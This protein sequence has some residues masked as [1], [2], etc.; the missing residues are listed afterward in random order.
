MP[1]PLTRTLRA[2]AAD[3]RAA[4]RDAP[5]EVALGVALAVAFSIQVRSK[6]FTDDDFARMA[7]SMALAFPLVFGLSVLA[8]RGVIGTAARWAGTAAVLVACAAYGWLALHTERDAEGWRW[9]LLAGAA[10][11]LLM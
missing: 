11:L 3:A 1:N 9:A 4:F 7:A 5:T 8:A 2:Y 10:V 6:S